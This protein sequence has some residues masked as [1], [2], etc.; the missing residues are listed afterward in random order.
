MAE[1]LEFKTL[2]VFLEICS[3]YCKFGSD[4]LLLLNFSNHIRI[5]TA[6]V[7]MAFFVT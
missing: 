3:H 6:V 7:P 4:I 2:R 5:L 1:R